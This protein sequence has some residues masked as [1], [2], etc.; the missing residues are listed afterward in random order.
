V[1][2]WAD[3]FY[4]VL[5]L[6]QNRDNDAV[7]R[8]PVVTIMGHVD[9]GKTTLLDALRNTSVA[10]GEAGGITQ[11]IGAFQVKMPGSGGTITFLDTPGHAAFSAMRARYTARAHPPDKQSTFSGAVRRG[12]PAL[13]GCKS[14]AMRHTAKAVAVKSSSCDWW[15]GWCKMLRCGS[16]QE[17]NVAGSALQKSIPGN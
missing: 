4:T 5:F 3:G 8:P 17:S 9:H 7:E 12:L 16:R 6:W 11:H 13:S 2:V 14:M 10:A 1:R 15:T